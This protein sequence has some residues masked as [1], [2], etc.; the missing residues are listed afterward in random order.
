MPQFDSLS[1]AAAHMS[2]DAAGLQQQI[3]QHNTAAAAAAAAAGSDS[4]DVWGKQY[5]PTTIDAAGALW[6][7]QVTPV[8]HYCM[9]GVKINERAQVSKLA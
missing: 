1:A 7:G 4:K 2:V 5:F 9:G 6:V 3:E 8:V